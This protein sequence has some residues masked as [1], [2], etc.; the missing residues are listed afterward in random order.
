MRHMR[1]LLALALAV[2]LVLSLA[3]S[4]FAASITIG[5]AANVTVANK[6]FNAYKILDLEMIGDGYVYTVPE[7]LEGFYA[8]ELGVDADAGDFD[9]QVTQKIAAMADNSDAL[10]AFAA[11]ALA[12]AKTAGITPA[13]V[14][15]AEG[16]TSVVFEN[17]PMGYYVIEDTG[18]ATPISAL[19]LDSTNPDVTITIKADKPAI[20]KKIDG[21]HDTDDTTSGMV[22]ANNGAVGDKVPYVITSKVPD[23]T[24]YTKYYFVVTDTMSEGLTFNNDVVITIGDDTLTAGEDY[25]VTAAS[26]AD[27]ETVVEI[28]FKNFIQYKDD[29]ATEAVE[30]KEGQDI[31]ISYS[32]TINEK[33][34][35]GVEGNPNAVDLTYSNNPNKTEDGTPDNPDKPDSDS[36]VGTTPDEITYTY[37]TDLKIIKTDPAGT[38]LE[39]AEFTLEGTKMNLVEVITETYTVS[40]EGEY[41]GLTNGTYTKEAPDGDDGDAL[42]VKDADGNYVKYALTEN[43]TW[44]ETPEQVKVTATVGSNGELVFSGLSAGEYTI[45]EIK[46]PNGYNLLKDPIKVIITCTTPTLDSNGELQEDQTDCTWTYTWTNA[47][48]EGNTV[49][50]VNQAGTE[51]PE[52]G[53]IGTTIFYVLGGIL[54]LAA[55]VLL[56]TKKRMSVN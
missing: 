39:G 52:T 23:M 19:M 5:N 42:Y 9:Y 43:S 47:N 26:N 54:V 2:M 25:T 35:I 11:K 1:K 41:Y 12:A 22:E 31:T 38:R 10:F 48:G 34:V 53:G 56:V 44:V 46:A 28:V 50:I 32:A 40:A 13:T 6:T 21:T 29:P 55:V 33:A 3:T 16:A 45:T 51:L 14:T 4:A 18:A 7:G 20:E 27:G 24:G 37:V 17:L 36:P 8:T 15:G 30:G 49:T